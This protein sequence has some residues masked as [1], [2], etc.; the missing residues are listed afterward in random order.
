MGSGSET[1]PSHNLPFLEEMYARFLE[2]ESSVDE[3]WRAYFRGLGER[4]P[5]AE[6]VFP[7]RSIFAPRANGVSQAGV[8][9]QERRLARDARQDRV[10]RL[11]QAYRMRGHLYANLDPLGI[12]TVPAEPHF[13]LDRFGLEA[14]DLDKTVTAG[15]LRGTV[16]EIVA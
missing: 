5:P 13:P 4:V 6:P 10:A 14:S 8:S 16:R 9:E 12:R 7:A 11:V 1:L 15:G 3:S 2:D